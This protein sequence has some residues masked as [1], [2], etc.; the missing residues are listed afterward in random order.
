LHLHFFQPNEI[1][2]PHLQP[3]RVKG[4]KKPGLGNI[5]EEAWP[6]TTAPS[7]LSKAHQR[8]SRAGL[9][10]Q[11]AFFISLYDASFP[12]FSKSGKKSHPEKFTIHSHS[13]HSHSGTTLASLPIAFKF[14]AYDQ[15]N[16]GKS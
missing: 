14:S 6:T 10:P 15:G 16:T 4:L 2:L 3:H 9:F 1:D 5:S 8:S 13:I 11:P 12:G 7:N